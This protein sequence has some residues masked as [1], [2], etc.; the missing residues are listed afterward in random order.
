LKKLLHI[1]KIL[2][3]KYIN[4]NYK[5][6]EKKKRKGKTNKEKEEERKE[7]EEI[8]KH[9]INIPFMWYINYF[10]KRKCKEILSL[11]KYET[12]EERVKVPKFFDNFFKFLYKKTEN[13]I[14]FHFFFLFEIIIKRVE[15]P[16]FQNNNNNEFKNEIQLKNQFK[17]ILINKYELY[18]K[19]ISNNDSI[20]EFKNNNK[21][22]LKFIQ[23]IHHYKHK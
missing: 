23:K 8:F 2:K 7:K 20:K 12:S 18:K 1:T 14:K 17:K 21:F 6:N 3:K 22:F 13:D 10:Q 4:I 15:I 19:I 16:N 11:F 9:E 5:I